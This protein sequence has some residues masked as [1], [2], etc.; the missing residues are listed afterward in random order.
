MKKL[1]YMA[2]RHTTWERLFIAV[3]GLASGTEN[4]QRRLYYAMVHILPLH[5]W[6]F[7]EDVQ[8]DVKA[9]RERLWKKESLELEFQDIPEDEAKKIA[10]KLVSIYDAIACDYS[11]S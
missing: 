4:I 6:E 8:E 2:K 3:Q 11:R 5:L 7:P 9:I 10:E 1:R